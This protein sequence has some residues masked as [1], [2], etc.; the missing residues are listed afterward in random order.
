MEAIKRAYRSPEHS[1]GKSHVTN[2]Y[3]TFPKLLSEEQ[4]DLVLKWAEGVELSD[5]VVMTSEDNPEVTEL[6]VSRTAWLPV[7]GFE[8]LYDLV[9]QSCCL[10]NYWEYEIRGFDEHMQFTEY[11]ATESPAYYGWHSDIGPSHNHRKI[12]MTIALNSGDEYT[13]GQLQ[14][15]HAEE[16]DLSTKGSAAMFPSFT[17]HQITPVTS[18]IRRS[19]VVWVSGPKLK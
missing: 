18:G 6:R 17:R 16:P 15:N 14:I 19:L 1:H 8:W 13:G 7:E 9:F 12:S 3:Y 10:T 2:P 11:D 4:C 5:G